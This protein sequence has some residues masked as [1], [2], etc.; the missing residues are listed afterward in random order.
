[1]LQNVMHL[2][3]VPSSQV[4]ATTL[5][6]IVHA[7]ASGTF[8]LPAQITLRCVALSAFR[9]FDGEV[10]LSLVK[11][12]YFWKKTQVVLQRAQLRNKHLYSL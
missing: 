6:Q 1:M 5:F 12:S 7:G 11:F 10:S 4:L 2:S 3:R 9:G 8:F